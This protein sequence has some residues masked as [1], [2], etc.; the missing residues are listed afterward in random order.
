MK[1]TLN[2]GKSFDNRL[3]VQEVDGTPSGFP[4]VL[5][6][7]NG[8][9]T[10]NGDGTFTINIAKVS[11]YER[12]IQIPALLTGTPANQPTSVD[13]FTVGGVQFPSNAN[14]SVFCQWEVPDDWAGD[15]VTFE[16]DWFPCCGAI[17]GTDTIKWDIE[18]RSIA[19]G[20]AINNGTS[21]TVS[22]SD[23]AD[24]AQYI[25]KHTPFTLAYNNANQPLVKQDHVYF[26]ITRDV[27][28]ANDYAGMVTVPAFEIIYN[29]TGFPRG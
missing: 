19:E 15:N 20:E 8:N 21:V 7:I 2:S 12:H 9:L 23:N 24:Y 3:M 18:Y 10:D 6:F 26:K 29:S 11:S 1:S 22:V 16:I 4:R 25:T 5:K 17:S 28:V 14:K 13:F 27:S